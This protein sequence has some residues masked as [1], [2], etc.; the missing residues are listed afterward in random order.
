[1]GMRIRERGTLHVSRHLF[2]RK[3]VSVAA[4]AH[5]AGFSSA[6]VS[7]CFSGYTFK[8]FSEHK[9]LTIPNAYHIALVE[10]READ[11]GES[12]FS[13]LKSLLLSSPHCRII[14]IIEHSWKTVPSI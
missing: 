10:V 4:F 5:I 12:W 14:F 2:V 13:L 3:S 1:M 9:N 8:D 7:D 11:T 6:Y